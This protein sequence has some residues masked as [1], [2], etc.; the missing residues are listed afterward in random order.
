MAAYALPVIVLFIVRTLAKI[1]KNSAVTVSCVDPGFCISD[2]RNEM[3]G[4][5]K[6]LVMAMER[7]MAWTAEE[8]SRQLIWASLANDDDIE[9]MRGA[10]I[11]CMSV[12]EPSD[13][14]ISDEGQRAEA[15]FW[16]RSYSLLSVSK[17]A[18]LLH[19]TDQPCGRTF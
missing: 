16:V 9:V 15:K 14:V 13:Y 8:G 18:D 17:I 4:I 3:K 1:L 11:C 10:F 12:S 5:Q 2:V 6:L 19:S 7:Y